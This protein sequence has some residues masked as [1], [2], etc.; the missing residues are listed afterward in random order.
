[1]KEEMQ[2]QFA[3]FNVANNN[4]FYIRDNFDFFL[5]MQKQ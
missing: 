1:M 4:I 5:I 2:E 3:S